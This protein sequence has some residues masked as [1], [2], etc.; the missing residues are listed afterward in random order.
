MS[1]TTLRNIIYS[2]NSIYISKPHKI[3]CEIIAVITKKNGLT[4][5]KRIHLTIT[6]NASDYNRD[7]LV[8]SINF[9]SLVPYKI[10]YA[11]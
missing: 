6:M 8:F 5:K 10:K 7:H 2:E 9:S 4:T 1:I 3:A 11:I